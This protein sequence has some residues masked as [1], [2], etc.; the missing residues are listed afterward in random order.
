ML[1]HFLQ[2]K[3]H[4]L[5]CYDFVRC[6]SDTLAWCRTER[7]NLSFLNLSSGSNWKFAG[8]NVY[9]FWV[10][11]DPFF[12]CHTSSCFSFQLLVL[13]QSWTKVCS[14]ARVP[15]RRE[16]WG[17]VG[18]CKSMWGKSDCGAGE[19]VAVNQSNGDGRGKLLELVVNKLA[20]SIFSTFLGHW[21]LIAWCRLLIVV[22][23]YRKLSSN[24]PSSLAPY[25]LQV[26]VTISR[27]SKH[28][29]I[30]DDKLQ[31]H[32]IA[33]CSSAPEGYIH[34]NA[35]GG[36]APSVLIYSTAQ[37]DETFYGREQRGVHG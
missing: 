30:H 15:L 29:C 11:L 13:P 22:S 1:F 33:H 36:S 2:R 37:C 23:V 35:K 7:W 32:P 10:L 9:F 18:E 26:Y 6:M 17:S 19:E 28:K 27:K 34:Q 20:L 12:L 14:V 25:L 5:Y 16:W 31:Y 24:I 8:G 3:S 4:H 21:F